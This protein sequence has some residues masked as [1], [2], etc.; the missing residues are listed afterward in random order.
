MS[1]MFDVNPNEGGKPMK[2]GDYIV[3]VVKTEKKAIQDGAGE[4][5]NVEFVVANGDFEGRTMYENYNRKLAPNVLRYDG[6]EEKAKEAAAKACEI[7]VRGLNSLVQAAG[8]TVPQWEKPETAELINKGVV[9]LLTEEEKQ[10]FRNGDYSLIEGKMVMVRTKTEK[11]EKTG[12]EYQKV[13]YVHDQVITP[14][15]VGDIASKLP[16]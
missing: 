12:K 10:A 7:G 3:K 5:I 6:D 11:N 4:A 1:D 2:A 13:S 15:T 16:F 14:E 9:R 8:F